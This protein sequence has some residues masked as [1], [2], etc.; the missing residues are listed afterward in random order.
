MPDSPRQPPL[1]SSAV[2]RGMVVGCH[3][4]HTRTRPVCGKCRA[5]SRQPCGRT[6]RPRLLC[7]HRQERRARRR[8][9]PRRRQSCR[10]AG[11]AV[12]RR[13]LLPPLLRRT[14]A[15]TT[16]AQPPSARA[17]SRAAIVSAASALASSSRS[18]GYI[19]TNY[20]VVNGAD[21]IHVDLN[22]GRTLEARSSA[23]TR[24]A[25]SRS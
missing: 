24:P 6:R 3:S 10:A 21:E 20:H 4:H 11:G 17:K 22:D 2:L 5:G 23:P 16:A 19:L 25:T 7:R 1:F 15:T 8:H 18:D 13:R 12:R 9:D 14:K